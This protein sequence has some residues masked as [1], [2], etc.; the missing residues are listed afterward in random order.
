[1]VSDRT[2][3]FIFRSNPVRKVELD[4]F[5]SFVKDQYLDLFLVETWTAGPQL[6]KYIQVLVNRQ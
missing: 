4:S 5:L 1:M 3:T 2:Q 6:V